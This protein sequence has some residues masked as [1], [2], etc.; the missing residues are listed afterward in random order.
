MDRNGRLPSH[1]VTK[2][3]KHRLSS[4][5]YGAVRRVSCEYDGGVLFLRGRL[6][7][8]YC[9]QLAQEAVVG[10]E[11]VFQVVNQIEVRA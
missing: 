1:Q 11:G 7:S 8:F 6:P 5:P 10:L 9:K 2:A 3:A 4:N